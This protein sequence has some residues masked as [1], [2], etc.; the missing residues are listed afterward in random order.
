MGAPG[1]VTLL[2]DFGLRDAYVGVMKGV[3]LGIA[4][5]AALVDLTHAIPPQGIV[6][7]ALVLRHAVEYFP[8]GTVHLAVVDPGVGSARH[9]IVV[10]TE[11]GMLVG[12]DNG[13]LDPAARVMGVR[14]VYRLTEAR[15]FRPPVSRT[16]HGR[17][18]FAPVA[19]HLA[20]GVAP[21]QCG[22]LLPGLAPLALP[23]PERTADA[24][25]GEVIYVD[26]FGNL[27]TNIP[28]SIFPTGPHSVSIAGVS[29]AEIVS[30]YAAVPDGAPLAIVGSWGL[31]EVAVRN[32]SAAAQ[33]G[34]AAGTPVTV[35]GA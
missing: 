12:P 2:S 10:D 27:V 34:A 1:I 23:E 19:A 17:D 14:A 16:F 3:M 28:E 13:L 30:A 15:F 4:P 20:A 21:A 5:A 35:R 8:P 7:G 29:L 9:P 6:P 33:L 32:G 11:R 22:P 26:H 18:L 24:I 25:R 31:V